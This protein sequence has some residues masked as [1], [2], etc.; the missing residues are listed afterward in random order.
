MPLGLGKLLQGTQGGHNESKHWAILFNCMRSR[1]VP[2]EVI[3]SMDTY[4]CINALRWFFAINGLKKN[5]DQVKGTKF[6]HTSNEL[7]PS[8][9]WQEPIMLRYVSEQGCFWEFNLPPPP[10]FFAHGR[11]L[12]INHWSSLLNT[13]FHAKTHSP[14]PWSSALRG[15]MS[16]VSAIVNTIPLVLISTDP[17]APFILTSASPCQHILDLI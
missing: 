5:P 3:G 13:R 9:Q 6:V 17:D 1:A 15:V 2:T 4:S 7:R 12:G 16:K 8:K 10:S 11:L 14:L